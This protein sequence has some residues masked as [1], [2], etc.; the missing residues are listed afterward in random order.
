MPFVPLM[1]LP[2]YRAM[3]IRIF[4]KITRYIDTEKRHSP[5]LSDNTIKKILNISPHHP[6][7]LNI[8]EMVVAI[9]QLY[10]SYQKLKDPTHSPFGEH[11]P[12]IWTLD[13]YIILLVDVWGIGKETTH[14][15]DFKKILDQTLSEY[16]DTIHTTSRK[17]INRP[18][19]KLAAVRK[20]EGGS[21]HI[22]GV[23]TPVHEDSST[24]P[25]HKFSTEVEFQKRSNVEE[26]SELLTAQ[27]EKSFWNLLLMAPL[28]KALLT[29][30]VEPA[31]TEKT[32]ENMRIDDFF[33]RQQKSN[34][35]S[36]YPEFSDQIKSMLQQKPVID[37]ILHP[38]FE[39]LSP[40][41]PSPT[42]SLTVEGESSASSTSSITTEAIQEG[43]E[44]DTPSILTHNSNSLFT[45][46]G[47][48]A[49]PTKPTHGA[50]V[51]E[52][53]EILEKAK[54]KALTAGLDEEEIQKIFSTVSTPTLTTAPS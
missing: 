29:S 36:F 20:V 4:E 2:D 10:A 19:S 39:P 52:L 9:K 17:Y 44:R 47:T 45:P 22:T 25:T 41:L 37:I 34:K 15:E 16:K 46:F 42:S 6:I 5:T 31:L 33:D 11:T 49:N 54:E 18:L 28:I 8:V 30:V 7:N 35:E 24:E 53:L 3:F 43:S 32:L 40:R 26:I 1:S 13:R 50:A 23:Y 14:W 38:V 12:T 21:E 27:I 51:Q 48:L